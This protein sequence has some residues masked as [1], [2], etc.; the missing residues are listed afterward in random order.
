MAA[1]WGYL[2]YMFGYSHQSGVFTLDS[3]KL[4]IVQVLAFYRLRSIIFCF[5]QFTMF[6]ANSKSVGGNFMG[7]QLPLPA[8]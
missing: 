1:R 7:V 6:A 8:P 2:G 5:H 3:D 4:L